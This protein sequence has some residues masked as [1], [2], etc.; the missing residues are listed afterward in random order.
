MKSVI[1]PLVEQDV[2][3]CD[4]CEPAH[5]FEAEWCLDLYGY[6]NRKEY[7]A[8]LREINNYI[9]NYP[10]LSTKSKKYLTYAI[11]G[12]CALIIFVVLIIIFTAASYDNLAN[13]GIVTVV[14]ETLLGLAIPIGRKIVDGMA[15]RRAE[16]FTQALQ[17]LLDQYNQQENPTANWKLVWRAVLTHFSITMNDDGKGKSVPKYAEHAELVIE[18]NDALSDLTAQTVRINLTPTT[19]PTV[20][21]AVPRMSTAVPRVS[22]INTTYPSQ[23]AGVP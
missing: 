7:A 11:A 3:G 6:L 14:L 20:S 19:V 5:T 15:K 21:T 4:C 23:M 13:T 8:R 16:I 22:T 18:I 2:S 17:P 9:R 12:I 1:V 10:L